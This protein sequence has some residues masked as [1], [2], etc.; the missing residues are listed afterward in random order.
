MQLK[1]AVIAR[2]Q[3]RFGI[4][5][6]HMEM[7]LLCKK[8]KPTTPNHKKPQPKPQATPKQQQQKA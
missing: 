6:D 8:K 4:L 3:A 2:P 7:G 5:Q 1:H